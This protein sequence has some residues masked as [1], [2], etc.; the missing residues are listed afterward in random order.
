MMVLLMAV[1]VSPLGVI[2]AVYLREYARQGLLVRLIR[3]AVNN[4]AGVPSIVYG[5]FGL[6]FF[7][8]LVGGTID[9]LFF[10]QTQRHQGGDTIPPGVAGGES[11]NPD[12]HNIGNGSGRRR[13][14]AAD[15]GGRRK[16]R[17]GV[18]RP[19]AHVRAPP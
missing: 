16:T 19:E 9:D 1:I 15:D 6:G 2:A 12:R 13:S 11:V 4:L 3:I 5:V 17:A 8:Y 14:C 18:A 10:A 7:V